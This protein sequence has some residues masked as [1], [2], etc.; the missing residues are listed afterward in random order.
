VMNLRLMDGARLNNERQEY[1]RIIIPSDEVGVQVE[2]LVPHYSSFDRDYLTGAGTVIPPERIETIKDHYEAIWYGENTGY[3][4]THYPHTENDYTGFYDIRVTTFLE[5][6]S[7]YDLGSGPYTKIEN[8]VPIK[9]WDWIAP[10]RIIPREERI[11]LIL[12]KVNTEEAPE[13]PTLTRFKDPIVLLGHGPT[14]SDHFVNIFEQTYAN[15]E[16]IILIKGRVIEW[17]DSSSFGNPTVDEEQWYPLSIQ[18]YIRLR[19]LKSDITVSESGWTCLLDNVQL[20]NGKM[21]NELLFDNPETVTLTI[22]TQPGASLGDGDNSWIYLTY[23]INAGTDDLTRWSI[24]DAYNI[25]PLLRGISGHPISPSEKKYL[26]S[27]GGTL[28]WST[29]EGGSS[30]GDFEQDVIDIIEE[31]LEDNP[32]GT[33]GSVTILRALV[34]KA[35]GVA[36]SELTLNWDGATVIVAPGA[37]ADSGTADNDYAFPFVDN[38]PILVIRKSNGMYSAI[39]LNKNVVSGTI[40]ALDGVGIERS[41]AEFDIGS[42]VAIT[43]HAPPTG[44]GKARSLGV[45]YAH[46]D[47]WIFEQT[48]D[49]KWLPIRMITPTTSLFKSTTAISQ[50]T[51]NGTILTIGTGTARQ[52]VMRNDNPTQYELGDSKTIKNMST[53]AVGNNKVL[54]CKRIGMHWFVDVEECGT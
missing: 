2:L 17:R 44:I 28:E 5:R 15:N 8:V 42:L 40:S 22:N 6:V 1:E 33:T 30:G 29:V 35:G 14:N 49:N 47:T 31:Y 37:I 12:A 4:T 13:S 27:D 10:P 3:F 36:G 7:W 45:E 39:K 52:L 26:S 50:A 16:L 53:S 54:Q 25:R 48:N 24:A 41:T 21:V 11:S 20:V 34:N 46:G 9:N 19:V 32:Q 18:P 23:D 38:E 51:W 43:G